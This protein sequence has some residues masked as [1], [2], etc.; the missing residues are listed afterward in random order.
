MLLAST[1]TLTPEIKYYKKY[2]GV[3]NIVEHEMDFFQTE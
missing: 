1:T 3:C 2:F